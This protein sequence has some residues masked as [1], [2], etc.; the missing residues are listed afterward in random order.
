MCLRNNNNVF[1]NIF[2]SVSK[3]SV[4]LHLYGWDVLELPNLLSAK[5][6]DKVRSFQFITHGHTLRYKIVYIYNSNFLQTC[7]ICDSQ[8]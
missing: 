7:Y 6:T 5:A 4:T 1:K 3:V 2:V 8:I